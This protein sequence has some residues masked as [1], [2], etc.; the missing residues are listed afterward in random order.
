[1]GFAGPSFFSFVER[2]RNTVSL[3]FVKS[4]SGSETQVLRHEELAAAM[5]RRSTVRSHEPIVC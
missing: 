1:L 2:H 3:G 5:H 4:S